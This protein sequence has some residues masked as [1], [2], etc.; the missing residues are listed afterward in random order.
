MRGARQMWKAEQNALILA[1]GSLKRHRDP[2]SDVA[3]VKATASACQK[4]V[5]VIMNP[6]LEDMKI[7]PIF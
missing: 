6:S 3:P 7:F 5:R 4:A 2:D 1:Y